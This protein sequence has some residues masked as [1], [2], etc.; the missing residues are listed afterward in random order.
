VGCYNVAISLIGGFTVIQKDDA[1]TEQVARLEEAMSSF[2]QE[3]PELS[4]A[5]RVLGMSIDEYEQILADSTAQD[6]VTTSNT[7]GPTER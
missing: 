7:T 3:N 1:F 6:I 5:I 4:E 2:E